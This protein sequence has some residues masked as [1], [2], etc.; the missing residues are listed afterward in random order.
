MEIYFIDWT[1][2]QTFLS[3]TKALSPKILILID[4]G[5]GPLLQAVVIIV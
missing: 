5:K 1:L 4:V 3:N 2:K